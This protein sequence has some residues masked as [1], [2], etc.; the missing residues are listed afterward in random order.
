M[1][2]LLWFRSLAWRRAP[3]VLLHLLLVLVLLAVIWLAINVRRYLY[4]AEIKFRVGSFDLIIHWS[5]VQWG[6]TAFTNSIFKLSTQSEYTK[7][8]AT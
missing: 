6:M 7:H 8:I 2:P 3:S 1:L 5:F 4:L